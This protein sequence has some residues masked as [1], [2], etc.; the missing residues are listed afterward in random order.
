LSLPLHSFITILKESVPDKLAINYCLWKLS[1][2][3]PK[4]SISLLSDFNKILNLLNV[5]NCYLLLNSWTKTR[6]NW[7]KLRS[8]GSFCPALKK[9]N[10]H[11]Y[12]NFTRLKGMTVNESLLDSCGT[13]IMSQGILLHYYPQSKAV[14][15]LTL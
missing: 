15:Y 6:N 9:R 14:I 12:F 7:F 2:K 8:M 13:P 3:R 4:D 1:A 10:L 11:L 5:I